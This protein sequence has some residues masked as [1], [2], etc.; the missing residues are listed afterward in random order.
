MAES[1][2]EATEGEKQETPK[3]K[4]APKSSKK[5]KPTIKTVD[6]EVEHFV[7]SLSQHELNKV[8][9]REVHESLLNLCCFLFSICFIYGVDVFFPVHEFVCCIWTIRY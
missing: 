6:L 5:K 3:K 9:E 1:T 7:S 4:E 8:I 2:E